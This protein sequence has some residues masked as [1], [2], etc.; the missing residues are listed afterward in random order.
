[1]GDAEEEFRL[2]EVMAEEVKELF[3]K[4]ERLK[5]VRAYMCEYCVGHEAVGCGEASGRVCP[6]RLFC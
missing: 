1:M 3:R 5:Q 4:E 6:A 2:D